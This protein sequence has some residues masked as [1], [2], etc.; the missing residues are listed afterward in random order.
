MTA[1]LGRMATYSGQ[2]VEWDAAMA[3]NINLQPDKL[4]WKA[5]PKVMPGADGMYACAIPG[6]TKV[7]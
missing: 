7:I 4:D 2:M 3:S 5:N 6:V 1:I